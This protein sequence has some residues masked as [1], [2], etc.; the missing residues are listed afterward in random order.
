MVLIGVDRVKNVE[1]HVRT[2]DDTQG[3]T[4]RC[5]GTLSAPTGVG[6]EI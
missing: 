2:Y 3:Y 5:G 4:P 6:V 1:I